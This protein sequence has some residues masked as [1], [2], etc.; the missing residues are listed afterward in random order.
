MLVAVAK[1]P[2]DLRIARREHWYRIP[3]SSVEKRLRRRW[4]PEWVA[5]YQTKAFGAEAFGVRYY[6]RVKKIREVYRRELFPGEPDHERADKPYY[7]LMLRPLIRL[8]RPIVSRRLRRLV[9]IPTT[10]QKLQ[11]AAE[12]NDLFDESPLEERLWEELRGIGVAAERQEYVYAGSRPYFLDFALYCAGGRLDVETDGDRWHANRRRAGADS[13]RDNAL[14]TSG[15]QVLRFGSQQIREEM[16]GYCLPTILE[17]VE[18]LG[19]LDYRDRVDLFP[20]VHGG[21]FQRR[22]VAPSAPS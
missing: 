12:I 8:E 7:Q 6:A 1:E 15:W 19:G 11:L 14:V 10:F 2:R 13:L 16:S 5:L 9:F 18:R 4:P 21:S 20:R 3:V 17:N 22:L